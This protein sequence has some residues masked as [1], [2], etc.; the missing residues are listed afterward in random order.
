MRV[1]LVASGV[2]EPLAGGIRPSVARA[3][4][5]PR[6]RGAGNRAAGATRSHAQRR[7][8]GVS[9]ARMARTATLPAPRP[10]VSLGGVGRMDAAGSAAHAVDDAASCAEYGTRTPGGHPTDFRRIG[11]LD[12]RGTGQPLPEM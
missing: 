10:A 7:V 1:V 3:E 11:C 8:G 2:A 4:R 12:T 5:A 9:M 6:G